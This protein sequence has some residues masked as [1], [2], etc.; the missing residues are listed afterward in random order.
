MELMDL[1]IRVYTQGNLPMDKAREQKRLLYIAPG[2]SKT[3][4]LEIS[5]ITEQQQIRNFVNSA[6]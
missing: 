1:I 5:A 3:Y 4:D 2:K 6:G